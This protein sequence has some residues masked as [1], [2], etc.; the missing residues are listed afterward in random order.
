MKEGLDRLPVGVLF[1][2]EDGYIFLAN[3]QVQALMLRF[4]GEEIKNGTDLWKQLMDGTLLE[5]TCQHMEGDLLIRT[6]EDAWRFARRS[7]RTGGRDYIEITAIQATQSLMALH[8]L[9]EERDKLLRQTEETRQLAESMETL[10]REQEYLRL[11]T[12]VH[13]ILGQ[14]LTAMQRLS[15]SGDVT[16]YSKLLAQS[17]EVI[18][19]IRERREEDAEQH[20]ADM[21]HYFQ[22]IG[23]RIRMDEELPEEP[24]LAFVFLAVLRE[25]CTNA[26]RHAAAGTVFV[27]V[28]WSDYEYRIDIGNDGRLPER[29]I[30]EGGGLFGM[31]SRVESAGG[32]LRVEVLPAFSLILTLPRGDRHPHH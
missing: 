22:N 18:S 1:C 4:L 12:Q 14:R 8:Q 3:R 16:H 13:D 19:Q 31:R 24:D 9:E 20:L 23:L 15:R 25:A 27:T 2:E 30:R 26:V 21:R 28:E 17:R 7:F 32:T 5:G 29:G 10:R 11:R 6:E